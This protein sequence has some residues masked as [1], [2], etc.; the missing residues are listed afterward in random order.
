MLN[1]DWESAALIFSFFYNRTKMQWINLIKILIS[2]DRALPHK[3]LTRMT[4]H[5]NATKKIS[6]K[7][8]FVSM[9]FSYGL[10]RIW[11]EVWNDLPIAAFGLGMDCR[12][13]LLKLVVPFATLEILEVTFADHQI[14]CKFGSM[15]A[16][17]ILVSHLSRRQT[18]RL[19]NHT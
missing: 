10:T 2:H 14:L 18:S 9:S 16:D 5:S 6:Q 13:N 4:Q 11:C 17:L 8:N 7:L 1:F 12:F 3:N 19:Y 15:T